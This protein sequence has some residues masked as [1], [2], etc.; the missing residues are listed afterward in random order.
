MI[1]LLTNPTPNPDTLSRTLT[2]PNPNPNPNPNQVINH[3]KKDLWKRGSGYH[4][5]AT[6]QDRC[7]PSPSA[8]A[9]PAKRLPPVFSDRAHRSYPTY[10]AGGRDNAGG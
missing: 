10:A 5:H 7:A 2:N 4:Y 3:G 1:I 9:Y 8:Y 6:L